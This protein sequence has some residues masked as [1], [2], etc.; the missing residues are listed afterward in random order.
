MPAGLVVCPVMD[1]VVPSRT[2]V[3]SA[4]LALLLQRV[5]RLFSAPAVLPSP[6][7]FPAASVPSG[8]FER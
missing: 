6:V 5:G 3:L 2:A 4:R 8:A 1:R 7:A